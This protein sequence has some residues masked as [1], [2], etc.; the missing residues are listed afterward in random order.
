MRGLNSDAGCQQVGAAPVL[1][2]TVGPAAKMLPASYRAVKR[3]GL[4]G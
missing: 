1:A 3:R 4:Q 2:A